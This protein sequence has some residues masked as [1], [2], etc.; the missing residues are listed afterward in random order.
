[1]DGP[2]AAS[3]PGAD[4]RW[5]TAA[6]QGS[7]EAFDRLYRAHA[8]WVA[9]MARSRASRDEH[10]VADVVQEVF[11]RA[12]EHLDRLRDPTR[13]GAWVYAIASHVIVDHHRLT[14]RSRPLDDDRAEE[15]ESGETSPDEVAEAMELA[16]L[17]RRS[18]AGLSERDATAITLVSSLGLSP[19]ELGAVLG[20]SRGAAKVVLHRARARLRA[21]LHVQVLLERR[22][23]DCDGLWG[24]VEGG[25]TVAAA[26]HVRVCGRCSAVDVEAL[27]SR[28]GGRARSA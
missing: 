18:V 9:Q 6:R 20:V 12:L 1:M 11:T 26:R 24:L 3:D 7:A 13:F 14:G 23:S 25:G 22:L 17:L 21:A 19:A 28:P 16:G 2:V 4:G 8:G 5:V 10:V 27:V 15:I